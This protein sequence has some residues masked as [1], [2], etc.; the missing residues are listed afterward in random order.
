[1]RT[2][3]LFT[4]LFFTTTFAKAQVPVQREAMSDFE[5]PIMAMPD[6][7]TTSEENRSAG[8]YSE[9]K[10]YGFVDTQNNRQQA[11]YDEI[12]F[13]SN[14][15]IV[16]K[17]GLYG[18][19]DKKGV[20]I[21]KID[22][23]SIGTQNNNTYIIKKKGKYGTLSIDGK[24]L[25][26]IKYSKI[27]FSDSKN[28]VSFVR[29]KNDVG[30]QLVFNAT[31]KIFA[32]KIE[33]AVLYANLVIV[34]TNGKFGVLKKDQ[35]LI[36]FEYDSI[37]A[38]AAEVFNNKV[39]QQ[40][41]TAFD[42]SKY[43]SNLFYVTLQKNGKYGL[44]NSDGI[45]LYTV[46]NDA[47]SN[48]SMLGYY[49]IKKEKLYGIYFLDGKK[50]TEV[51]FDKVYA[52]GLGY[53]MA[54]KNN[55]AG[56]FNLKGEQIV[57]F[58]YDNDFIAQL[59]GIGLRVTKDKKR[60]IIDSKGTILVPTI[61]DDVSTFYE[62]GFKDFIKV[63]QGEKMGVVNLKGDI[64][65]PTE[66]EW[67][68]AEKGLF[69]VSTPEPARKVGLYDKTGNIIVPV[70]YQWITKSATEN[71]KIT[72]L[73][74]DNNSYNFLNEKKQLVFPEN[75]LDYGYVLNQDK[76][77]NPFSSTGNYLLYVK[78]KNGKYG[79]LN[80]MSGTL[81]IPMVYDEI[82][83]DFESRM[84]TYYSVKKGNKFGLTNETNQVL[85][86][87]EY[88]AISLDYI[89]LNFESTS[90]ETYQ[91][92][93]AKG[94][95]YGSVNL[96]N[97]VKIPFQYDDL[98]L[99]SNNGLYKA[100]TG[101]YYQIINSKNGTIIKAQ[102]DEVANFEQVGGFEYGDVPTYQALTFSK[103][104][105]RVINDKGE[106]ISTETLMLPHKGYTT[107][108]ELKYTL[109]KALDAKD[110]ILLKEF[111]IKIAPSEHILY[112]LKE[113]QFDD[114]PLHYINIEQVQ[115]KYFN[116]LRTFKYSYWN[117]SS[118]Y[119]HKR[120]ALTNV[121]DYTVYRKGFV[122]NERNTDQAFG[123]TRFLEKLLRNAIKINGYWISS[124]FMKRS[125]NGF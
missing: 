2:L 107:F 74:K 12:K 58:E 114:K 83:Q 39:K 68:D 87:I 73:M 1:M 97:Q 35:T 105:M 4:A 66:F 79:M 122:T 86:P 34:K 116:D 3:S 101:N 30:V 123:D 98:E 99:I 70:T 48:V 51:E 63:K 85:I 22:F 41:Y 109:I 40:K 84:H 121:T 113:N 71:S 6:V 92:V 21:G 76:L 95:K 108:D 81:D 37:F 75:V 9:N 14:G 65:I 50:K 7:P 36:P 18:I 59:T 32:S 125:F 5:P 52:D 93:V 24:P 88:D 28:G 106:F 54:V 19:T 117:Q 61:Y 23:D 55:K 69:K 104:K 94:K 111:A 60:G 89:A 26:A 57:P 46:E 53:V 43:S 91:I 77:L 47:L 44:A 29:V 16:K 10:K 115:E 15:F 8:V 33:S 119:G 27:L 31:G 20:P 120:I 110:D 25:L 124:Y 90:D 118:G 62:N 56:V 42:Y 100:K 72:V 80:E 82:L 67:V 11:I 78:D 64:I 103:G 38:P 96:N 49:T 102:F 45:I 112:Y 13:A 17:D